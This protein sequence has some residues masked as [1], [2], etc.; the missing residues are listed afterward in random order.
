MKSAAD[1]TVE[2]F[3]AELARLRDDVYTI[4]DS[5]VGTRQDRSYSNQKRGNFDGDN[6][7]GL[8]N[9]MR[10]DALGRPRNGKYDG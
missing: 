8:E 10:V 5:R 6:L 2:E 1:M 9:K 4:K 7:N 3:G